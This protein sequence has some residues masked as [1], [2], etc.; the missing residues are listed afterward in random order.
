M[1]RKQFEETYLHKHVVITLF[2]NT[3]VTGKLYRTD[4]ALFK[5]EPGLHLRKNF[6]LVKGGGADNYIFRKT[7]IKKIEVKQ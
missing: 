5:H 2:D 4:D 1:N 3:K 7:H 6:Y